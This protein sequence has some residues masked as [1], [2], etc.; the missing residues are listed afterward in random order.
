MGY[1]DGASNDLDAI[2]DAES[3]D[4]NPLMDFYSKIDSKKL[5]IQGRELPFT[6][7]DS[8]V[9]GYKL[10]NKNSLI[11]EIDHQDSFFNGKSIFYGIRFYINFII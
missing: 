9:L 3:L 8:I 6:E 4:S 2:Y 1:A 7:N 5:V 11:L 10:A